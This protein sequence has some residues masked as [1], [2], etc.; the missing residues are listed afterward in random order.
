MS[1]GQNDHQCAQTDPDQVPPGHGQH[2]P[3]EIADQVH[4]DSLD[5]GDGYQRQSQRPMG[6]D[7]KERVQRESGV[8]PLKRHR[9][10]RHSLG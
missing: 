1:D 7:S 6:E 5:K 3:K 4:T 8:K 9:Q 10:Q 2:V